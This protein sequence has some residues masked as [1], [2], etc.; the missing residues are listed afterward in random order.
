MIASR[1]RTYSPLLLCSLAGLS[2]CQMSNTKE[3]GLNSVPPERWATFQGDELL[4]KKDSE[5]FSAHRT[6]SL[7]GHDLYD[8][9]KARV[10]DERINCLLRDCRL[11]PGQHS[12]EIVYYWSSLEAE[13]KANKKRRTQAWKFFGSFL[14]VIA[15]NLPS[16]PYNTRVYKC[17]TSITFEVSAAQNYALELVQTTHDA[18]PQAVRIIDTATRN[19]VSSETPSC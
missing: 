1:I 9:R 4:V 14:G 10:R 5:F 8:R 6:V 7:N 19:I 2:A 3:S 15:G 17:R 16:A 18:L 13:N 12:I 11:R